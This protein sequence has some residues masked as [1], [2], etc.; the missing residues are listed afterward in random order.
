[1]PYITADLDEYGNYVSD[2]PLAGNNTDDWI[3]DDSINKHVKWVRSTAPLLNAE[4]MQSLT[5]Y[6][7]NTEESE[8]R[9]SIHN[10]LMPRY[11]IDT[12]KP[13]VTDPNAYYSQLTDSLVDTI[14]KNSAQNSSRFNSEYNTLL[15]SIKDV[16]PAAYY[17]AQIKLLG[18]QLGH[19]QAMGDWPRKAEAEKKLSTLLQDSIKNGVTPQQ[20]NDTLNSGF[21]SGAQLGQ[22][23]KSKAESSDDFWSE[24]LMGT[25][26]IGSLALG[27][28]G[29]DTAL[30][31]GLGAL[32]SASIAA[33]GSGGGGAFVPTAGSSF[34][35]APEVAYTTSGLVGLGDGALSTADILGSTGFT[36]TA[37]SSFA[38]DPTATYT[39]AGL[40][41]VAPSYMTQS[42]MGPTYQELGV[43][44]VPEGGMGPTYGEMG[45]TGLNQGE[46]IAAAD[47]A[48][49]GMSASEILSNANKVRSNVNTLAKLL[50]GS[51]TAPKTTGTSGVNT[52][53][54]ASLLG[55][56]LPTQ[57]AP[58]NIYRMNQNPFTFGTQGQTPVSQGMYDVSGTS[59]MANALRKA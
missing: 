57:A 12:S 10:I 2:S 33:G 53:Q 37:G 25:L 45:Y 44:G 40:G 58:G 27:A 1:M 56:N 43:T 19:Y 36:P 32:D 48:S 11:E 54:L 21:S 22:A 51:S 38:I 6:N 9:Y 7:I 20:I 4:A 14:W 39:T 35:I 30:G 8:P 55:S 17:N 13:A 41:D 15:E 24:N 47:A 42:Q 49:K 50:G 26:K 28:Y 31:A 3:W 46:A 29:L 34:A 59:P 52:Q 23:I 16:N 5:P 18:N